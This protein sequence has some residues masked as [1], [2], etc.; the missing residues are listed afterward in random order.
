MTEY[1]LAVIGAGPAG[2]SAAIEAKRRGVSKIA[3]I[4]RLKMPGGM[5][6]QCFHRGFGKV[7]Y[8]TELT[9]PEF[10]E[11]LLNDAGGAAFDM[12]SDTFA[13]KVGADCSVDIVSA[14]GAGRLKPKA[15]VFAAGCRERPIGS[16]PVYGSRPAGVFTAGSVQRMINLSGCRVGRRAVVL[17]SGDVGMIVSHHLEETGTR[18]IAVIERQNHIGGLLRNKTR[19]LDPHGI[20]VMTGCTIERLHGEK[21][22]S[23]VTVSDVCE[24]GNQAPGTERL[25]ECD[26]LIT[27]VGLIP[28]LEPLRGLELE[29]SGDRL[30]AAPQTSIPWLFVCGNAN[31]VHSLVDSVVAEGET[32]G[33]LAADY[34]LSG[35][36]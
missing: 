11:R 6:T 15:V 18:V 17:G 12:L 22:L 23:G 31:R 36:K 9:G 29:F 28:E 2:I 14:G 7:G 33:E 24:N 26:T 25:I 20:P 5:L 34:I 19:Y 13:L 16:L 27:S 21:R 10:I 3:V 4:D 1:E 30:S 8:G 32:A 35:L